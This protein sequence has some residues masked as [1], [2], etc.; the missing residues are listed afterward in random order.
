MTD[1]PHETLE[2]TLDAAARVGQV[3]AGTHC[4]LSFLSSLSVPDV[5]HEDASARGAMDI[6]LCLD[7]S[8]SMSGSKMRLMTETAVFI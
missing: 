4:D 3:A 6:V 7:L 5:E 2:I 8:G 1:T